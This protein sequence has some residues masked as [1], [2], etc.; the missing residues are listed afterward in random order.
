MIPLFP[1]VSRREDRVVLVRHGKG[2][3]LRASARGIDANEASRTPHDR[4]PQ[5]AIV[6]GK[7]NAHG[8]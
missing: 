3:G 5:L 2:Q 4:R 8:P 7:Q 6:F 1:G